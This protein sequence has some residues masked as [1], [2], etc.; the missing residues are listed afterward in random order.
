MEKIRAAV[1]NGQTP[2]LGARVEGERAE[3]IYVGLRDLIALAYGVKSNQIA[4]PDWISSQPYDIMA[5]MPTGASKDDAPKML[6]ALLADRF[7]L[8][9]HRENKEVTALALEVGEGGPKLKPA[10]APKPIDA[11]APLAPGEKQVESADGPMRVTSGKNGGVMN[12]GAK[13]ALGYSVDPANRTMKIEAS[14]VTMA[15]LGRHADHAHASDRRR[16]GS[17]RSD[18]SHR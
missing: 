3:Y 14:Q 1:A 11:G 18:R 7:K 2:R 8:A 9:L 13:G 16:S 10:E 17:E 15:A 4:G 12:M 5:K 6:Q